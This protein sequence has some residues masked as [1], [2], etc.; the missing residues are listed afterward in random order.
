MITLQYF[1]GKE[2]IYCDQWP[3]EELCWVTLGNDNF[4]YRTV[5]ESGKV[6]NV[7]DN[8]QKPFKYQSKNTNLQP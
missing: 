2:W 4:N 7:S 1:N 3:T 6:L 8:F 5:D